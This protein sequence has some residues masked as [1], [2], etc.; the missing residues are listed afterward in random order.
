LLAFVSFRLATTALQIYQEVNK[1]TQ[2]PQPL[3]VQLLASE[4][5]A[6]KCASV[7]TH[8]VRPNIVPRRM[9]VKTILYCRCVGGQQAQHVPLDQ[10][11]IDDEVSL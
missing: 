8:Q 4:Q 1:L 7:F 11:F 3:Y 2:G 6:S 10:D 5:I 9:N